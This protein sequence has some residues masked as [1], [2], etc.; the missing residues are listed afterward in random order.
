[1]IAF[2]TSASSKMIDAPLPP[3]SRSR[4]VISSPATE[5]IRRPTAVEPVK[6]IMSTP[7]A[8][9]RA[10]AAAVP[11]PTTTL[12]TPSGKP[13]S[14]AISA[15]LRMARGSCGAGFTIT[16]LPA[17]SAGPSLPAMLVSGKL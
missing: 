13:T 10:S 5:P 2:P 17:A 1:M 4:R 12:M 9:T 11:W 8:A 16:G 14:R 7:G 15:N 6:L 3:S